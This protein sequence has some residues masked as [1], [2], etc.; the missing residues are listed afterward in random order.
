M[1]KIENIKKTYT[2]KNTT[3]EALKGIDIE[4]SKG[5]F[6]V[7]MGA[8]GSGKSTLLNIIGALDSPNEGNL[9]LR[10]KLVKDY[11][12]EPFSSKYRQENIGFIFQNF[13]L[14][15][16]LTVEDNIAVPL[17]LMNLSTNEISS[18]VNEVLKKVKLLD[19]RGHKPS[20]L[21]GG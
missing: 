8:S 16:D 7:I 12:R 17:I 1:L 10:N 3:V 11:H 2:G 9:Y 6:L 20:E 13:R 18:K 14:L 5:E 19:H 21:S 4:V 15:K